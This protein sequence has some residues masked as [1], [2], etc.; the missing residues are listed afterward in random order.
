MD[1]PNQEVAV[2]HKLGVGSAGV[3]MGLMNFFVGLLLAILLFITVLVAGPI[4]SD[5]TEFTNMNM[6]YLGIILMPFI[7]GILGFISGIFFA[8][9]YNLSAKIGR[10]LKLYSY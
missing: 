6:I 10:G 2:V 3:M 4:L 1:N 8:L 7:L 5:Y 9:F